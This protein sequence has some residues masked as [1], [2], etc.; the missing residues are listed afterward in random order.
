MNWQEKCTKALLDVL[1]VPKLS[2][3]Q[4][5]AKWAEVRGELLEESRRRFSDPVH[6]RIVL[7][8]LTDQLKRCSLRGFNLSRIFFA[9]VNF[10]RAE[11][12][13]T[14]FRQCIFESCSMAH[15]NI[16]GADFWDSDMKDTNLHQVD[17]YWLG[18]NLNT[19]SEI[20]AVRNHARPEVVALSQ[21]QRRSADIQKATSNRLMRWW[22]NKTQLGSDF[23]PV[24]WLFTGVN[25]FFGVFYYVVQKCDPSALHPSGTYTL[26]D[27]IAMALLRSLTTNALAEP[28]TTWLAYV[29]VLNALLGVLIIGLFIA[30][31]T[32]LFLRSL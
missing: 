28:A 3:K 24:A 5:A 4:R 21:L 11:L 10:E 14:S 25:L 30:Q 9:R 8:D 19:A 15:A 12:I 31:I 13:D 17:K 18:T 2:Y 29:C 16:Q 6:Q 22:N 1:D 20:T 23:G 26:L 32:K 27:T 7:A